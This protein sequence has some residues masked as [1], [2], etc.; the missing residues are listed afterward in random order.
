MPDS[1]VAEDN[2]AI[3]ECHGD[4]NNSNNR[5]ENETNTQRTGHIK[6]P[7]TPAFQ[8]CVSYWSSSRGALRHYAIESMS[9]PALHLLLALSSLF[10]Y[11]TE[12]R[13]C[14]GHFVRHT[15]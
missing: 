14:G 12:L 5:G 1:F 13:R 7:F 8:V 11:C 4:N 10:L 15:F 3:L 2:R 9:D 6:A